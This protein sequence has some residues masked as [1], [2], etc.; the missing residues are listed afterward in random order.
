MSE[1]AA[2][3][4][5]TG[6]NGFIGSH[7][8]EALLAQG[9]RVR[10]M[11]RCSSDLTFIRGLPVEWAYADLDNGDELRQACQ[12]VDAVC[13]CAALT[14]AQD[15]KTFMRANARGTEVLARA[16][17]DVAPGLKRFL[18]V[19]SMAACGPSQD[20]DDLIDEMCRSAPVTW[21]GSSKLA[22]EQSLLALRDRLPVTIIRAAA[23]F[24][25]RDRDFFAYFDLVNRGLDLQ[26]G[27]SERRASLIYVCDLIQLLLLGLECEAAIGQVY[28]GCG[29]ST[30]YAELSTAIAR[31]LNKQPRRITLPLSVLTPIAWWS[32]ILGRLTGKPALLNDQRVI[33]L[34]QP[35]WLCSDE[36]AQR[37][38]GF[39]PTYDLQTALQ[40]TTGWYLETGWL[41]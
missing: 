41:S 6:A 34:R 27:G 40:E 5:V 23:A 18:F 8:T 32:K 25:P 10:C 37:D 36:K 28:L 17:L 13:H 22:A 1:S 11:V 24:G 20:A 9:Y 31:T 33:D 29:Q 2:L 3:V 39:V 30:A 26:L 21:Y 16:C 14:R 15:E 4:L 35:F 38:L 19:S 7:L 12:G